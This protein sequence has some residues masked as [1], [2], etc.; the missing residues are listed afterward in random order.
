MNLPF[1]HISASSITF[2]KLELLKR[3]ALSRVFFLFLETGP[4]KADRD[5]LI[6]LQNEFIW[7]FNLPESIQDEIIKSFLEHRGLPIDDWYKELRLL[8]EPYFKNYL[9]WLSFDQAIEVSRAFS[10]SSIPITEWLRDNPGF[11]E[12]INITI[13][14][15]SQNNA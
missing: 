9:K 10:N 4:H 8:L 15:T 14:N 5:T 6:K 2:S 13:K 12:Y 11:I 3:E 7:K 1:Y